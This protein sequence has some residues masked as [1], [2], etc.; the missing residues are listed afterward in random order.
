MDIAKYKNQISNFKM[1]ETL[2]IVEKIVCRWFISICLFTLVKSGA[3][4]TLILG[5]SY[6]IVSGLCWKPELKKLK[7]F[8]RLNPDEGVVVVSTGFGVVTDCFCC[9]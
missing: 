4:R 2:E 6:N 9:C 3:S 8:P 1:I 7:T 5:E